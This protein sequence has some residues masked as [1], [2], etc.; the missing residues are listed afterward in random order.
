MMEIYV[1]ILIMMIL[2]KGINGEVMNTVNNEN[3]DDRW[4]RGEEEIRPQ[5]KQLCVVIHKYGDQT[6]WIYQYRKADWIHHKK[7][8]F[9]DVSEKWNLDSLGIEEWNP[10]FMEWWGVDRWKPLGLPADVEECILA[11]IE[12]WFEEDE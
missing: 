7:D 9:L 12:K 11:E 3:S 4:H 1:A 8:Y 10:S 5:D 6:P 2:L